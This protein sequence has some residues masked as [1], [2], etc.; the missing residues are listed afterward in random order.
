MTVCD[1]VVFC[2]AQEGPDAEGFFFFLCGVSISVVVDGD[3][4]G[5]LGTSH[6]HRGLFLKKRKPFDLHV[7]N[8]E[9]AAGLTC[10]RHVVQEGRVAGFMDP[11]TPLVTLE[12][13]T[14]I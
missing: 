6:S 2:L 13:D 10:S 3:P 5:G 12:R 11:C 7:I 1:D 9:E 4:V 8:G 14:Y